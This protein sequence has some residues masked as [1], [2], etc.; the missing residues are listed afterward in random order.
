V[1]HATF[2]IDPCI[3]TQWPGYSVVW[4]R[5]RTRY[6]VTVMNPH[7]ASR[8]VAS[9]TLDGAPVDSAAIPILDDGAT[10]RVEIALIGTEKTPGVVLQKA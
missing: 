6:E 1:N 8:G 3:P 5:G 7:K 4:V 2:Q 9:A 10:H